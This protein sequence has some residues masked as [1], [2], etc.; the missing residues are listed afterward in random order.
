MAGVGVMFYVLLAL[1]AELR[2]AR[3]FDAA[4]QPKLDPLLPLV[5]WAPWPTWSS[6]TP[7]TAAWSPR[8]SSAS[9]LAMPAGMA[10]LLCSAAG[11]KAAVATTFDFGFAWARAST[12]Q[13][14][15]PT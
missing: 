3:R 11:R 13:G 15:W 8:A 12:P 10:A 14:A 9:A 2:A 4:T 5:A 1:R 7:T 6:S